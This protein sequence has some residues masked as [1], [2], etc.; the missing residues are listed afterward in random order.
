MLLIILLGDIGMQKKLFIDLDG[1]LIDTIPAILK[2]HGLEIEWP[3]GVYDI[4]EATGM[5][6][7]EFFNINICD[8]AVFPKTPE[9]DDI[10]SMAPK[11]DTYILSACYWDE[12][13]AKTTW[14][15]QCYPHMVDKIIFTNH[16]A[17][18]ARPHRILIDDSEANCLAWLKAGGQAIL[19][20]RPWNNL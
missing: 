9:A 3:K 17:L 12:H 5:L 16:K 14:I 18:L 13:I 20:P 15:K 7:Q 4:E 11:Y 6:A 10:M 1:V 8:W 19:L 2:W